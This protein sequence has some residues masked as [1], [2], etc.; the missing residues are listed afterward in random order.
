MTSQ[1]CVPNHRSSLLRTVVVFP[2]RDDIPSRR[3]PFVNYILIGLCVVVYVAQ[4]ASPDGGEGM[5]MRYGMVPV[6]VVQ[7]DAG[8]RV[9][10]LPAAEEDRLGRVR[11][12]KKEQVLPAL[13]IPPWMT[14][15][16]CMFL[17]GSLMHIVG[18]MWFLWIFGDN[19]EDRYGSAPY[20][21]MYLV[22]GLAAGLL[23]LVSSPS[24]PIPTVGASGAIAGVM[25]AYF[26]LFPHARVV[27]LIPLGIFL[28]TAIL[29]AP[30]FL[31]IWFLFQIASAVLSPGSMGGVAWWAHVGGF[32]AGLAM[33]WWGKESGWLSP[34]VR[35]TVVPNWNDDFS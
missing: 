18:N 6:R 19:V 28:Q 24:S 3:P 9:A 13:S 16:T 1:T 4:M 22:S 25:G 11:V 2:I 14:M 23:Q 10:M 33:T 8:P 17:H 20:L 27:T 26:L 5:I 34:P 29:P 32:V 7:N 35:R 12:V 21:L 30:I 31:G 15:F